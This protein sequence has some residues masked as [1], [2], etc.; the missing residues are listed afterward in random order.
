M[1]HAWT[2]PILFSCV[3]K[4]IPIYIAY[5]YY[6]AYNWLVN[7]TIY[8]R[9]ED[10]AVWDRAKELAGEKLAPVIVDGLKKYVAQRET[11][12]AQGR[13]FERIVLSYQDGDD[14]LIP[15]KKAFTG[16]WIIPTAKPFDLHN[17]EGSE[18]DRYAVAITA[19]NAAVIYYWTE[20]AEHFFGKHFRV[21]PSL[22]DAAANLDVKW[23][24]IKAIETI[25]VP[26]DEL[27][28]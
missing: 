26:V 14:N 22:K 21:F 13:G 5:T 20:D 4:D 23:A 15:K 8:I 19:K 12:E 27:D 17:E 18:V 11:E 9:D 28:I 16:R 1:S 7:K 10:T 3:Y 2:I 24:A 6:I 25:G